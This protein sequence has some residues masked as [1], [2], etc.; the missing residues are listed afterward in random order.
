MLEKNLIPPHCG[1]K[2]KINRTFPKNLDERNVHI[3]FKLTTWDRTE[4]GK[5]RLFLNNFSAAG[6]PSNLI[7]VVGCI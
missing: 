7:V 5:R 2:G 3:P 4:G 6:K 1:I